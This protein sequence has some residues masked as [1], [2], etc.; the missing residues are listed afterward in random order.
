VYSS[1]S[2]GLY[3][4]L[5]GL[6]ILFDARWI[7]HLETYQQGEGATWSQDTNWDELLY[8][9]SALWSRMGW[10]AQGLRLVWGSHRG[11]AMSASRMAETLE[12]QTGTAGR[13]CPLF[14]SPITK[15]KGVSPMMIS[16]PPV[17][18]CLVTISPFTI[19]PLEELLHGRAASREGGTVES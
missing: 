9:L 4:G 3:A 16:S 13:N 12:A 11:R 15:R 14:C 18:S 17:S 7:S 2:R 8:V 19:V 6:T 10:G 1:Y 5:S